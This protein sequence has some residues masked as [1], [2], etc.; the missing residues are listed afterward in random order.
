[1]AR[2]STALFSSL[3]SKIL[4]KL[5]MEKGDNLYITYISWGILKDFFV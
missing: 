3:T 4:K 1:M 2:T 5:C